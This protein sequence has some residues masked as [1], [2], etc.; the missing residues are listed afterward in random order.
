MNGNNNC[1]S[2]LIV[3]IALTFRWRAPRFQFFFFHD[4]TPCTFASVLLDSHNLDDFN[5]NF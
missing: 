4:L 1:F 3:K 2:R 5:S